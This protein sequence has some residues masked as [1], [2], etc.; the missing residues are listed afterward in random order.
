MLSVSERMEDSFLKT[1]T[2][3]RSTVTCWLIL[4]T[5]IARMPPTASE[6]TD[7]RN[8]SEYTSGPAPDTCTVQLTLNDT[9]ADIVGSL[10]D[11]YRDFPLRCRLRK[12]YIRPHRVHSTNAAK[13][14]TRGVF[15]VFEHP[16]N[17]REK[18]DKQ[19][20]ITKF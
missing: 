13:A 11:K 19:N 15:W 14:V 20:Q 7:C 4:H 12:Y 10:K 5:F 3:L 1:S 6:E 17:F 9:E 2:R 8:F 18:F 16:R